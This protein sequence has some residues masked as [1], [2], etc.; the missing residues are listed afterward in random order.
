MKANAMVERRVEKKRSPAALSAVTASALSLAVAAALAACGG[1]KTNPAEEYKD[2][3]GVRPTAGASPSGVPQ[4]GYGAFSVRV[5]DA[6]GSPVAV[7]VLFESGRDVNLTVQSVVAVPGGNAPH[8][9]H[10]EGLPAGLQLVPVP[11]PAGSAANV[12]NYAIRGS[13]AATA[14]PCGSRDPVFGTLKFTFALPSTAASN[15]RDFVNETVNREAAFEFRVARR[16]SAPRVGA[17]EGLPSSLPA[18]SAAVRFKVTIDDVPADVGNF[19]PTV[20]VDAPSSLLPGAV[21]GARTQGLISYA[22]AEGGGRAKQEGGKWKVEL[23]FNPA[24]LP[25]AQGAAAAEATRV[26]FA[27]VATNT[28]TGERSAPNGQVVVVTRAQ[29]R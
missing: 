13:I 3:R 17:V 2:L 19:A 20:T 21:N 28:C 27:L 6:S 23:S 12:Q 25:A 29:A 7:P 24:S 22:D 11:A 26:Q 9:L 18:G 14:V 1:F 4:V 10:A 8:S 16:A 5:L 15:V